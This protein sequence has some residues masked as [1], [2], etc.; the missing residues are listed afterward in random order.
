MTSTVTQTQVLSRSSAKRGGSGPKQD[1]DVAALVRDQP[2]AFAG[3]AFVKSLGTPLSAIFQVA[4]DIVRFKNG[5]LMLIAATSC[6]VPRG[7]LFVDSS[8]SF[9]IK[10]QGHTT[11]ILRGE[12]DDIVDEVNY[13]A[14][15]LVGY[16]LCMLAFRAGNEYAK[17]YLE[18]NGNPLSTAPIDVPVDSL[19]EALLINA[20]LQKALPLTA[21]Q[22]INT[23]IGGVPQAACEL[24]SKIFNSAPALHDHFV[25]V[26][27]KQTDVVAFLDGSAEVYGV[28]PADADARRG[29]ERKG[30]FNAI[31]AADDTKVIKPQS[32]M[33][34]LKE[35]EAAK[36]AADKTALGQ[37]VLRLT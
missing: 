16:V 1:R 29:Y 12:R 36:K 9:D 28:K 20:S 15:R 30:V 11:L 8:D 13:K 34:L 18:D 2:T 33:K 17:A 31:D 32:T 37:E 14:L 24:V 21:R 35:P 19:D 10:G 6:K 26:L 5:K 3:Y 23:K 22:E 25:A 27:T 4:M 7:I